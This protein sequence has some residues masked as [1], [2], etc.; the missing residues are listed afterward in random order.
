MAIFYQ[1]FEKVQPHLINDA[2]APAI[3]RLQTPE[4][5]AKLDILLAYSVRMLKVKLPVILVEP[6]SSSGRRT[7]RHIVFWQI[8]ETQRPKSD[9][10]I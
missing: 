8:A 5:R 1:Q 2:P 3:E 10:L 9:F 4:D 7:F 6:T